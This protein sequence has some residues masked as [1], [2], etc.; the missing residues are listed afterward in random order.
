MNTVHAR[1]G[2]K[3][4]WTCPFCSLLCD[5]FS[6]ERG[7]AGAP[8]RLD[9]GECAR[10]QAALSAF[11]G[12]DALA[13]PR[14]DGRDCDLDA[15]LAEAASLLAASR[16]PLFG[17][18]GADVAGARALYALAC[19]TG[20]ICDPA[21]GAALMHG[22]RAL[23]DRGGFTITFAEARA[24]ADLVVCMTGSPVARYP[25]FFHRCG[26]DG[27]HGGLA[28]CVA[29]ADPADDQSALGLPQGAQALPLH[30]DLLDTVA[31]LGALVAG[32]IAPGDA[33]VPATLA[34]LAVSLQQ[35]R[36]AVLVYELARLPA[37]GASIVEAIGR[38][39]A[40]LNRGARAASIALGGHAATVNQVFTWLSGLPLRSRASPAGLEHEPLCFDA[41][42]LLA[43]GAVDALLWV[44]SFDHELAAPATDL[45]R[46]VLGHP[47]MRPA[48]GAGASVFIPVSTPGIGSA[49]HL[50]RTDGLVLMP[51]RALRA[52]ALPS[53]S[54]VAQ[55]LSQRVRMLKRGSAP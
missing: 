38:I 46:I 27:G 49:G 55:D 35:A 2:G 11:G 25:R 24:R 29:L 5:A 1:P 51:L 7:P 42:R 26:L 13:R 17:G 22:V 19:E 33:R 43:D 12:A 54:A 31:L 40:T 20:A 3:A 34:A 28:R 14:V 30:G 15:A 6:V 21:H 23:Q 8:P 16:Q 47:R 37:H 45:P 9:G 10:A 41:Q 39:V 48:Q 36:Y 50:F 4:P 18:L 52:D 32:K 53:V 44:S